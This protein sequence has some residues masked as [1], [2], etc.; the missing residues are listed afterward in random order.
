MGR[1]GPMSR[2]EIERLDD[3]GRGPPVRPGLVY[4][5][6]RHERQADEPGGKRRGGGGRAAV[7]RHQHRSHDDGRKG[8]PPGKSVAGKGT[9]FARVKGGKVVE[10]NSYPDMS[11]MM[12]QLGFMPQM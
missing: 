11:G 5:L 2:E 10:F 7:H 6:P 8:N 3:Q 12:M 9:Y 4:G 1:R